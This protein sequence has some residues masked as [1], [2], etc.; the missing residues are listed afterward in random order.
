MRSG[1]LTFE[2]LAAVERMPYR[3]P[4]IDLQVEGV[5]SF[6]TS[7][8]I[9]HNCRVHHALELPPDPIQPDCGCPMR[10]APAGCVT[11]TRTLVCGHPPT[12]WQM[13]ND[14]IPHWQFQLTR[15]LRSA[16]FGI[17]VLQMLDAG[18]RRFRWPHSAKLV[19]LPLIDT[20]VRSA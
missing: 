9:A 15:R 4:V 18:R 12:V 16:E 13:R 14:L 3:G 10:D 6:V 7:S 8:G 2:A 19:K 5:E 11:T 20:R 1:E 17:L